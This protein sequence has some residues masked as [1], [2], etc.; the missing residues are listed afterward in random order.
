M[1]LL[2]SSSHEL[3]F[4]RDIN[5]TLLRQLA[6]KGLLQNGRSWGKLFLLNQYFANLVKSWKWQS[7]E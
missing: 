7:L 2:R 5:A 4:G 1:V 3:G 6:V